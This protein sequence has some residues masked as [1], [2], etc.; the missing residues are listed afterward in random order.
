[1]SLLVEKHIPLPEG[2]ENKKYQLIAQVLRVNAWYTSGDLAE[3][4]PNLTTREVAQRLLHLKRAGVAESRMSY[5]PLD[6]E[7]VLTWRL[8]VG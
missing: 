6:R 2:F 5:S 8:K 1:M 4:L 3:F 7:Y